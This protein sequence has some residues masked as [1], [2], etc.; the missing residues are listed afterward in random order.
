MPDIVLTDPELERLSRCSGVAVKAYLRIRARMDFDTGLSGQ[1]SGL[2][3]QALREWTEAAVEKGGGE[4]LHQPTMR[5]VRTAVDQLV[6]RGLL[7]RVEVPRRLVFRCLLARTG[8]VRSKRTRHVRV[9]PND[10]EPD[11]YASEQSPAT[12]CNFEFDEAEPDTYASEQ[13][14]PNPTNIRYPIKASTQQA[15]T[16]EIDED[17]RGDGQ[18][19]ALGLAEKMMA[20]GHARGPVSDL[21]GLVALLHKRGARLNA[22]DPRVLGW[23]RDAINH[24]LILQAMDLAQERRAQEG[25]GQPVNA[26]LLDVIVR[27]LMARAARPPAVAWWTSDEA[28]MG[29][30]RELGVEARPGES[31]AEYRA[32]LRRHLPGAQA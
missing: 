26:G 11:T 17:A 6:R 12:A 7:A 25:S 15:S 14:R 23:Q 1:R 10:D 29:K 8:E 3:Y 16:P 22:M 21:V 32:R 2:S 18:S 27:D 28:T 4:V 30:G 13:N 31:M 19:A 9:R 24:G 20:G 5:M